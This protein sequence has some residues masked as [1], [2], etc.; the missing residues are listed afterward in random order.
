MAAAFVNDIKLNYQ[1]KKNKK[2][3]KTT[4]L[5]YRKKREGIKR[6]SA[7]ESATPGGETRPVEEGFDRENLVAHARSLSLLF[8][9]FFFFFKM[10][11]PTSPF[12]CP[13]F[14]SVCV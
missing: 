2:N 10:Y 3:K 7:A 9:F 8:F 12:H 14:K 13:C 11:N 5:L 6:G 1:H 4:K